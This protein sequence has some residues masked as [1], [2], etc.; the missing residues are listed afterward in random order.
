MTLASDFHEPKPLSSNPGCSMNI[1]SLL[2]TLPDLANHTGQ[3]M[4]CGKLDLGLDCEGW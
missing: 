2:S 3:G 1:H 4:L